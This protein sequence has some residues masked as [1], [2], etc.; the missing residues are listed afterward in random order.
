MKKVN[1]ARGHR[2]LI[3]LNTFSRSPK[4]ELLNVRYALRTNYMIISLH[5]TGP[6]TKS[7][8]DTL[9]TFFLVIK[10]KNRAIIAYV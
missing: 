4:T 10:T 9:L 6:V 2:T 3:I 5:A 8:V 1:H 7:M